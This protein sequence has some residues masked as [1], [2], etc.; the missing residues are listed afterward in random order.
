M[1]HV[2]RLSFMFGSMRFFCIGLG[3][4]LNQVFPDHVRHRGFKYVI[5]D[6]T[7]STIQHIYVTKLKGK[8]STSVSGSTFISK[9]A[10]GDDYRPLEHFDGDISFIVLYL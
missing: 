7:S 5:V 2:G 3:T 6:T 4:K 10:N 8:V 1:T 9:N